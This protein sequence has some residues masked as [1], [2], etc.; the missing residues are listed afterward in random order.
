MKHLILFVSICFCNIGLSQ[1]KEP[2]QIVIQ[3]CK[4]QLPIPYASIC[5]KGSYIGVYANEEGV[6][7]LGSSFVNLVKDSFI[8]TCVGYETKINH[9]KEIN[10]TLFCLN[11]SDALL[12]DFVVRGRKKKS[13]T[14]SI[15]FHNEKPNNV[16]TYGKK[17]SG[18]IVVTYIENTFTDPSTIK[19]LEYVFARKRQQGNS[20][21]RVRLFSV[22]K[23]SLIKKPGKEI[24]DTSLV[25]IVKQNTKTLSVDIKHLYI[26]LPPEGIFVGLEW[27]EGALEKDSDYH[28]FE[29]ASPVFRGTYQ[30]GECLTWKKTHDSEWVKYHCSP[31]KNPNEYSIPMFGLTILK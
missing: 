11:P 3:D 7:T 22:D 29:A 1:T 21:I 18:H 8:V 13:K 14:A 17:N 27:I 9:E 30:Q 12:K 20:V 4:T 23:Y 28:K 31:S 5:L 6:I 24:L 2:M 25:Q 15:G 26:E 19:T 10:N 16:Y